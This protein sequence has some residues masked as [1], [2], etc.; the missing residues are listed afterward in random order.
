MIK[1]R[2]SVFETNSSSTHSI[3]IDYN[4]KEKVFKYS[5]IP[6]NETIV[7]TN[8]DVNFQFHSNGNNTT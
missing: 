1:I 8:D 5:K 7:I 4:Y 3:S 6:K 2:R